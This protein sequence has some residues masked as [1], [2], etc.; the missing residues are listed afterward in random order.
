MATSVSAEIGQV[1]GH[2]CSCEVQITEA[3]L[4]CQ[5]DDQDFVIFSGILFAPISTASDQLL[6]LLED[7][8]S[9]G[10]DITIAHLNSVNPN[11]ALTDSV[12]GCFTLSSNQTASQPTTS[13]SPS[14][15]QQVATKTSEEGL[16][17][18]LLAGVA[19]GCFILGILSALVAVLMYYIF[20]RQ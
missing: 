15:T 12:S 10:P 16:S 14:S 7:W 3:V 20:K 11:C 17:V 2:R 8:V 9:G 6:S 13:D 4:D 18:S 1:L 19:A 5:S